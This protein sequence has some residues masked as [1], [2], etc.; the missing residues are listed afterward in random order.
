MLEIK[1][2]IGILLLLIVAASVIHYF[3]N[4]VKWYIPYLA[5]VA[6]FLLLETVIWIVWYFFIY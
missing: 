6:V 5:S 4:K 3:D 2:H 1:S